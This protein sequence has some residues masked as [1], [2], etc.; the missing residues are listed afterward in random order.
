M[1]SALGGYIITYFWYGYGAFS[2]SFNLLNLSCNMLSG[3]LLG[4][5]F[6]RYLANRLAAS[7]VLNQFRI[8]QQ[9]LS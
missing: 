8:S 2:F 4:G 6:A 3:A 1:L 9:S 5:L 7:G